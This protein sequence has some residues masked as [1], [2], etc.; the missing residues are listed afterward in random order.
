MFATMNSYDKTSLYEM[1]Y[2]F[3]RRF[4]FIRIPAPTLPQGDDEDA[5]Q[6]LD[7]GMEEYVDA[8]DSLDPAPDELRAVGLVWKHTNQAVEQR[9]IGPAIVRDMLG[10]ITTHSGASRDTLSTRVTNAVVS[11]IFPQLEGV[12]ERRDIVRN[13]AEINPQDEAELIDPDL[14]ETAASDMLQISLRTDS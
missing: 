7:A 12:P 1:S 8:W 5:L 10:Y 13:I 6:A 9:S 14:L 4:A 3:M 11:Y 2:A